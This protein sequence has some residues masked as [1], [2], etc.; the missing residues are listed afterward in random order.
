MVRIG[1]RHFTESLE[2]WGFHI[3]DMLSERDSGMA[4]DLF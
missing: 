2:D 1:I 3:F 4:L